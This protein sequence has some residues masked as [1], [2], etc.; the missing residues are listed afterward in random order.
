MDNEIFVIAYLCS[1]FSA[2]IHRNIRSAE[3]T[4]VT[5]YPQSDFQSMRTSVSILSFEYLKSTKYFPFFFS[6]F[7][8]FFFFFH[9][10]RYIPCLEPRPIFFSQQDYRKTSIITTQILIYCPSSHSCE[11]SKSLSVARRKVH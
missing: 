2:T 1:C 5:K 9:L 10:F 11:E 6:F 3:H 8:F 4:K 7:F